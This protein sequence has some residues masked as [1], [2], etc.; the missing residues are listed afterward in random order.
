MNKTERGINS[1]EREVTEIPPEQYTD[2]YALTHPPNLK[3][4]AGSGEINYL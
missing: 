4:W 2:V 3:G 1:R